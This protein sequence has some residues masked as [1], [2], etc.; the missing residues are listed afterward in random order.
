MSKQTVHALKRLHMS[1]VSTAHAQFEYA[2]IWIFYHDAPHIMS[3]NISLFSFTEVL[4]STAMTI[5][6]SVI[7]INLTGS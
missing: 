4:G 2:Q 3:D 6:S 1:A 5:K 7:S